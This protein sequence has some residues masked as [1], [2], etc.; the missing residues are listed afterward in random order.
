MVI[1]LYIIENKLRSLWKSQIAAFLVSLLQ[2]VQVN[3]NGGRFRRVHSIKLIS[4]GSYQFE[5]KYFNYNYGYLLF[6]KNLYFIN[7]PKFDFSKSK[8]YTDR[9]ENSNKLIKKLVESVCNMSKSSLNPID[10]NP[11]VSFKHNSSDKKT[12]TPASGREKVI[13][14]FDMASSVKCDL[15]KKS[16]SNSKLLECTKCGKKYKS[17]ARHVKACYV[18]V[19]KNSKNDLVQES[20]LVFENKP[21]KENDNSQNMIEVSIKT[22]KRSKALECKVCHKV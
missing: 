1:K 7:I 8:S 18:K 19:E 5:K 12:S 3:T 13:F 16:I 10:Q 21:K 15:T 11:N 17:L 22:E 6:K 9:I 20:A 14:D 2:K 4:Y